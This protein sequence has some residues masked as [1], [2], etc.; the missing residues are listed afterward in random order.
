[1]P[2]MD[3]FELATKISRD[4]RFKSIPLVA[5]TTRYSSSDIERGRQVGFTRY[6]EKL[7]PEKL[8]AAIDELLL[9]SDYRKDVKRASNQ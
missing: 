8:I 7:N 3:G 4:S 5:I 1:M 2:I 9:P 6:L